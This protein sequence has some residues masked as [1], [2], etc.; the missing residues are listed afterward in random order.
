MIKRSQSGWRRWTRGVDD[1]F[2]AANL[3]LGGLV[4]GA[5]PKEASMMLWR[6]VAT[7]SSVW[8]VSRVIWVCLETLNTQR[9]SSKMRES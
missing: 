2:W 9:D 4:T 8:S 1:V 5:T 3:M 6:L 7:P